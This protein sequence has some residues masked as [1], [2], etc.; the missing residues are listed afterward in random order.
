M[1]CHHQ[2]TAEVQT[3]FQNRSYSLLVSGIQAFA[4]LC[5]N[6]SDGILSSELAKTLGV[7]REVLDANLAP[8]VSKNILLTASVEGSSDDARYEINTTF[9]AKHRRIHI[10]TASQ[11][12]RGSRVIQGTNEIAQY[13]KV[14]LVDCALVR[15]MKTNKKITHN[16]LISKV[17]TRVATKFVPDVRLIKRRIECCIERDY[18]TR[19][20]DALHVYE[21]VS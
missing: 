8:L 16:E 18:M 12:P 5:F 10:P 14:Y 21:Y 13:D 3:S 20:P 11:G 15:T 7:E 9:G 1:W 4:L 19:D 17:T 2:S 6:R